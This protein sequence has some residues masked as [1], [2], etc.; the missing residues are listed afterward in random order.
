MSYRLRLVREADLEMV[1]RWRMLPE[2]TKYM[3][4]DPQLTIEQQRAWYERMATSERD[5]VWIIESID[6]AGAAQSIGLLSLSEIDWTNRR[7]AWAYYL[8]ETSARGIGLAK[9]L[10]LTIYAYVFDTLGLNKLWCEVF[11]FNDRV[12]ALHEKF[13][14][15][16][17][18]VARQH[19]F[20][21]G[22][23]FDVVRMGILKS[24]WDSLRDKW[25]WTP[26]EI[27]SRPA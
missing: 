12:V 8:G 25:T 17:E 1:M 21:N 24:E 22:E 11:S 18:G 20:K 4:T 19:I 5:R 6:E 2:V 27:E 9:S 23:W 13:G 16:V 3:Y 10:E 26:I 7:C 15:K 14:S